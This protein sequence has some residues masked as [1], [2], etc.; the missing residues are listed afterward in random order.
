ME[1][2][3]H[4]NGIKVRIFQQDQLELPQIKSAGDVVLLRQ[5]KVSHMCSPSVQNLCDSARVL[6]KPVYRQAP[7][8][9]SWNSVP[10]KSALIM[11]S[12]IAPCPGSR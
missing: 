8:T 4:H 6:P 12:C 3:T 5:V 10:Q 9:I 11:Q 7:T 1:E 2:N